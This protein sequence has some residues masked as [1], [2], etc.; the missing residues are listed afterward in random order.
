MFEHDAPEK[1]PMPVPLASVAQPLVERA[2]EALIQR[3]RRTLADSPAA[4][5][6]SL[7]ATGYAPGHATSDSAPGTEASY[8]ATALDVLERLA[9]S[10]QTATP[11]EVRAIELADILMQLLAAWKAEAPQHSL[12]LAL[13]GDSPTVMA[14]E[15]TITEVTRLVL[16]TA[17]GLAPHGGSVRVS[18]RTHGEGALVGVRQFETILGEE[19][20]AELFEPFPSMPELDMT[21]RTALLPLAVARRL[22]EGHGG[23]IWAESTTRA[24]GMT[25]YMWWANTPT[26]Q[27]E[28]GSGD[29]DQIAS[30]ERLTLNRREP[31]LLV[32]EGDTRMARYL[33]ANLAARGFQAH[34]CGTTDETLACIDREEPDLLLVDGGLPA[35]DD[36]SLLTRLR[37]CTGAPILILARSSD[38]REC[39]R[40]LDAGAMDYIP[41]PFNIEELLARIRVALRAAQPREGSQARSSVIQVG[42]LEIDPAHQQ[43]RE[44]GRPIALSRTEYRLLRALAQHPGMIVSHTQLLERV[45]GVGYGQETEFLWVYI[46]RLRRKIEP[47]PGRPQYILTAPGVGYQLVDAPH[48]PQATSAPIATRS[49]S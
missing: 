38:P 12:E 47:D 15:A 49:R 48:I 13:P 19:R 3:L 29:T 8:I 11:L 16:A 28:P 7:H 36:T 22:V 27:P 2:P 14:D 25:F 4:A 21:R 9:S 1:P 17:I 24:A 20:L 32:L 26:L 10:G 23:C 40:L 37:H 18:L 45:W 35:I 41:R 39:A 34:L 5:Q 31:A 33:R 44:S 43:V 42:R 30:P 46:R 6:Q